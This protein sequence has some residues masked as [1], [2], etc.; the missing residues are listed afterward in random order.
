MTPTKPSLES[1]LLHLHKTDRTPSG[2]VILRNA[3]GCQVG[4]IFDLRDPES[5]KQ[6]QLA[7]EQTYRTPEEQAAYNKKLLE[8]T[9]RE[10]YKAAKKIKLADYE[11]P[12]GVFWDGVLYEDVGELMSDIDAAGNAGVKKP[13]YVWAA[14]TVNHDYMTAEKIW[15]RLCAQLATDNP[16]EPVP[17][18]EVIL[19]NALK[20]FHQT[21]EDRLVAYDVDYNLAV[22]LTS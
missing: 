2:Y 19:D 15:H 16:P 7:Y 10:R 1:C 12:H 14:R 13:K 3:K 8:E 5:K 22:E 4:D 11:G 18:S 17:G 20:E 6:L 9:E 21:N